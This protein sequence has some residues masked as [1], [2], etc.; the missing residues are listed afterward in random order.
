MSRVSVACLVAAIRLILK[1]RNICAGRTAKEFTM[2]V[3][4]RPA[5]DAIDH[6]LAQATSA[7]K[8]AQ[9]E[10]LGLL[11]C[12]SRKLRLSLQATFL[13]VGYP[14]SVSVQQRRRHNQRGLRWLLHVESS[15]HTRIAPPQSR[16]RAPAGPLLAPRLAAAAL[17]CTTACKQ[18]C[19]HRRR[20]PA[21]AI[22]CAPT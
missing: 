21:G 18:R 19:C 5:P 4:K 12:W 2:V 13:P 10:K 9:P 7:G 8:A 15:S 3:Q 1:F 16:G 6:A 17:H 22:A 11:A 14:S 20:R